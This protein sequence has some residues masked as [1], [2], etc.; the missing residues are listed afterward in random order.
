MYGVSR[1]FSTIAPFGRAMGFQQSTEA[2]GLFRRIRRP[3]RMLCT[4]GYNLDR[5]SGLQPSVHKPDM[6]VWTGSGFE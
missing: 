3:E 6:S 1:R 4:P 2:G 5:V